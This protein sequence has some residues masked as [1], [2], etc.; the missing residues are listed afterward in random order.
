[1][2]SRNSKHPFLIEVGADPS[3]GKKIVHDAVM[4]SLEK[5]TFD[6]EFDNVDS[7]EKWCRKF[8]KNK[9]ITVTPK[10]DGLAVRLVYN[11]GVLV[12]AA[13]RGNG[14]IGQDVTDN[15]KHIESI[16]NT[17][18]YKNYVEIR[19]EIYMKKSVF[20]MIRDKMIANGED[21]PAN[22]RNMAS[23]SLN[24]KD[25]YGTAERPL[26]FFA[27]DV[28]GIKNWA[29]YEIDAVESFSVLIPELDYVQ[30]KL[31]ET[32]NKETLKSFIQKWNDNRPIL[33]YQI[34]G[35]VFSANDFK[36]QRDY[37]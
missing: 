32:P 24:Q 5:I 18:K 25:P 2:K 20:H 36:T 26:H 28:R 17:I 29:D 22:P 14:M 8:G 12:M 4:G 31:L 30:T 33:N 34:D 15:I 6:D 23:G 27:Y 10:I 13:T 19:G 37:G 21:A 9:G 11:N 16:P 3:Y 35:L 7:L 1:M